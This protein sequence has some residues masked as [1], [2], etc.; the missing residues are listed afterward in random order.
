MARHRR[1]ARRANNCNVVKKSDLNIMLSNIR[2][3][4]SKELSLKH[5]IKKNVHVLLLNETHLKKNKRLKLEG[6]KSYSRN[7]TVKDGGGIAT[8][9]KKNYASQV[10]KVSEGLGD[11]EYI[12]TRHGQFSPAINV[13]NYYGS[14]EKRTSKDVLNENWGHILKEIKNIEKKGEHLI[15]FG[16]MNRHVGKLV[17]GNDNDNIS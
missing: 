4:N 17:E 11:N 1:R 15:L 2:G 5:I 13:I 9:I 12:I 3:F 14:Q 10:L 6:F 16:D 8:S 7:R